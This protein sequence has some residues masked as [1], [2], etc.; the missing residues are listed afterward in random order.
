IRISKC[1]LWRR[2]HERQGV[3]GTKRRA[4]Q[5]RERNGEKF[6]HKER[7]LSSISTR[8]ATDFFEKNFTVSFDIRRVLKEARPLQRRDEFDHSPSRLWI[9][10]S[11]P[12][13]LHI[14]FEVAGLGRCRNGAGHR[15]M[16]NDPFEEKLG[17]RP[18][19]EFR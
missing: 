8:P 19:V 4:S 18:A 10:Y 3:M 16:R 9:G 7:V 2:E 5:G 12:S 14:V 11:A 1:R 13:A 6:S 15:R 17:P